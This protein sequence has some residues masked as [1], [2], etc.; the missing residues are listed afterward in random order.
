MKR[1]EIDNCRVCPFDEKCDTWV[2]IHD[3]IQSL[4]HVICWG[5]RTI[6]I[7]EDCPMENIPE[8]EEE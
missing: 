6:I 4:G 3:L 5:D 7:L 8:I 2:K 1:I